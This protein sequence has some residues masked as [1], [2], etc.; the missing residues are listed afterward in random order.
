[1]TIFSKIIAGEVPCYKIMESKDG[2]AILDV[3]PIVMGHVIIIS[4]KEVDDIFKL[5]A[6]EVGSLFEFAQE[7]AELIKQAIPCKRVGI[8]VIGLEVPHAH[9][10]LVPINDAMDM[11][12]T[13]K[14]M[15]FSDEEFKQITK[16]MRKFLHENYLVAEKHGRY[17]Q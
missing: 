1:M 6:Q 14:R 2:M 4:R 13:R 16:N 11:D 17:S 9:I 7:V 10:H 8:A 3:N 5:T 15:Q 12:F